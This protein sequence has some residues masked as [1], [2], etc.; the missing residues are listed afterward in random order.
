M[1]G[2]G[3]NAPIEKIEATIAAAERASETLELSA[4]DA[5]RH[6]LTLESSELNQLDDAWLR[7]FHPD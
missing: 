2:R 3:K 4:D 6:A 5:L 7:E 1:L